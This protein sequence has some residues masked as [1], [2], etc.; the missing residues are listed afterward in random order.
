MQSPVISQECIYS[1]VASIV[2]EDLAKV[3]QQYD[4]NGEI[5]EMV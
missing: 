5:R 3:T 2:P 4:R 1:E